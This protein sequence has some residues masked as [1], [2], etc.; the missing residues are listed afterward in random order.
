VVHPVSLKRENG[1]NILFIYPD[2]PET[3]WSFSYVMKF[4]HVVRRKTP[5]PPLGILT[6][7][8][9]LPAEWNKRLVDM[10]VTKLRDKDILWADMVMISAMVVQRDSVKTV[11]ERVADLGVPV[12]VGGPLFSAEVMDQYPFVDHFVFGEAE[13]SLPPYIADLENGTL[14]KQYNAQGKPDLPHTPLPDW[15]LI[16]FRN[17]ATMM[18]QYSRG[19]PFDCEF[20]D[21]TKLYGRVPRTKG[22]DQIVS[23]LDA[24]YTA[25]WRG[26][27]FF[28]DDNFIG[29]K[30]HVKDALDAIGIWI[31]EHR[32]PFRFLTEASVNL[33]NDDDLIERMVAANFNSVFLG[34]ETPDEATLIECNKIQNTNIDVSEA[35]KKL[36]QR[37]LQVQA[38]FIVGFDNDDHT[39]FDRQIEFIQSIGV[40]VAMVGLL[41][42]IRGTKLY[43]RLE[44]EGRILKEGSGNNTDGNLNFI[45]KMDPQL[46]IKGHKRIFQTIYS[47]RE[48]SKRVCTFIDEYKPRTYSTNING[49][50]VAAFLRLIL[51]LG[52]LSSSRKYYWKTVFHALSKNPKALPEVLALLIVGFHCMKIGHKL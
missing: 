51:Y 40:G 36:Q 43:S 10:H 14:K 9:L 34:L 22:T 23:E 19:C 49:G 41:T 13:L 39:I 30:V 52:I 47:P 16:N 11:S 45:P 3:F 4:I 25:G 24:L 33:A 7:S 1:M 44:K 17:Y 18:V 21:I 26:T 35:V 6:V 48:F 46:L 2:F 42:A 12:T 28:V 27:V 32:Y 5:F 29:N 20:C 38:G 37:G 31:K 15:D 8:S 50:E